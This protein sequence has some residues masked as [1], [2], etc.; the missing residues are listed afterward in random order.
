MEEK[1]DI[2]TIKKDCFI[3][4]PIGNDNTSIRRHID[5]IIDG[6]II[7]IL[8]ESYNIVV[9]H[10]LTTPGSINN[11]V[12]EAIYKAD[13]VIANLTELNPNVMYEL[14][15]KHSIKKPVIIIM[16][17]GE[18]KLPF[19][20]NNE[21][22]I[23]YENDFQGAID[24]KNRLKEMVNYI[25]KMGTEDINNPIYDALQKIG[26]KESVLKNINN[27]ENT[28]INELQYII[29]RLDEIER[30]VVVSK[31]EENI[32]NT[33]KNYY[34]IIMQL[35]DDIQNNDE[36]EEAKDRLEEI[37]SGDEMFRPLKTL[38]YTDTSAIFE[39]DNSISV[40][41]LNRII[42]KLSVIEGWGN[43][44]QIGKI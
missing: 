6:C 10:R 4:T 32:N 22:T 36:I 11:Q 23:F 20:I 5:G 7:P 42:K 29:N 28:N 34:K 15:F 38:T 43:A 26:I 8:Q 3:I 2:N 25:E 44:R 35:D 18:R 9:A 33:S 30:K 17:K 12:I 41:R 37:T 19:D 39:V 13:L 27:S 1:Q 31:F 24:L 14:A 16:E 40:A 21:R